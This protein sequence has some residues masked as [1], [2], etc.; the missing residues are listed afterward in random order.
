MGVRAAPRRPR[1]RLPA[2]AHQARAAYGREFAEGRGLGPDVL[3]EAADEAG[4]DPEALLAATADDAVKLE[5]RRA[6]EAAWELGVQGVPTL[7]AGGRL[8][9]GD[10]RLEEAAQRSARAPG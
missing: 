8:Y 3:A 2:A 10:D 6:T 7:E 9:F 1:G 5:L 4:L